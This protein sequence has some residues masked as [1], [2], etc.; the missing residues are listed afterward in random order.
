MPAGNTA[1]VS[2]PSIG[3]LFGLPNNTSTP[4]GRF[5]MVRSWFTERMNATSRTSAWAAFDIWLGQGTSSNWS[6]EVMIQHDFAGSG[7]CSI[8]AKATFPGLG[9]RLQHWHLCKYGSELIWTLGA[10]NQHKVSEHTGAVH[11]LAMLEWLK[12]HHYLPANAGLWGVG[13]GW[14]ICSTGG[15]PETF[16]VNAF[17]LRAVCHHG[18]RCR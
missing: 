7:P 15:R 11:I 2:Y 4:L 3:A 12:Q 14:E 9:G 5:K 1:V 8:V 16:S 10:D 13:Y 18:Q 6:H 17:T